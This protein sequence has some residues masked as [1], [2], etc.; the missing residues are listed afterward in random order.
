MSEDV[1]MGEHLDR[2]ELANL[3][4]RFTQS[5]DR[6]DFEGM[7][8]CC[9]SQFH[10]RA[11]GFGAVIIDVDSIHEFIAGLRGAAASDPEA[12]SQHRYYCPA[13]EVSGDAARVRLIGE[14]HNVNAAGVRVSGLCTT[15][16]ALR[17]A[18]GWGLTDLD[19][20]Y[21]WRRELESG[22]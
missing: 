10:A 2:S 11:A 1:R 14:V 5:V 9:A 12:Q 8:A 7:R 6:R 15:Y 13:V 22:N 20:V 18:K 17:E 3:A 21:Q 4:F 19:V 16:R